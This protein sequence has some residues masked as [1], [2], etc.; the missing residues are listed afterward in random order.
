MAIAPNGSK[1]VVTNVLSDN[2]SIVNLATK[3]VEAIIPMGDRVQDVAITSD[4]RWAVVCAF[5]TNS[6]KII[7]LATNTASR[8]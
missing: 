8:P 3:Q 7:D 4:S 5:N 6:V 1:A 2:A